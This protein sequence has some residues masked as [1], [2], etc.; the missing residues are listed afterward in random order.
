MKEARTPRGMYR[1]ALKQAI[2]ETTHV[3]HEREHL[4]DEVEANKLDLYGLV[5]M[6]GKI[7]ELGEKLGCGDDLAEKLYR[8][9]A[10]STSH[11]STR[12]SDITPLNSAQTTVARSTQRF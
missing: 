3:E 6:Q 9:L 7:P 2:A 8:T 4:L 12:S 1:R 5:Q 10:H 11:L